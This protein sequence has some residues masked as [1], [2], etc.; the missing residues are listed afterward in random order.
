MKTLD[1]LLH[2]ISLYGVIIAVFVM[3]I[4]SVANILLRQFELTYLWIDP[5]VRH[6]VFLATFL[7][8]SLAVGERQHIKIDILSRLLENS[9]NIFLKKILRVI[10]L[11]ATLLAVSILIYSSYQLVLLE[12][13]SSMEVFL[14]IPSSYLIALITIGMGLIFFF[15]SYSSIKYSSV[16]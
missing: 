1:R 8:G 5:L 6:M 15:Q 7:G 11:I 10:I 3:L 16:I 2:N 9:P 14:G 13:Q 12:M 4:L